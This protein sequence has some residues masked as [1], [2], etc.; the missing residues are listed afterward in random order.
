MTST[1]DTWFFD[2]SKS[3]DV[4]R[5]SLHGTDTTNLSWSA[6]YASKIIQIPTKCASA[7]C[8]FLK[9][10]LILLQ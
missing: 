1:S 2:E 6:Y 7:M 3:L 9:T 10:L 8:H 4:V 5:D